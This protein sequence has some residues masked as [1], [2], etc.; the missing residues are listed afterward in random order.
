MGISWDA[1][2]DGQ[3]K[4]VVGLMISPENFTSSVVHRKIHDYLVEELPKHIHLRQATP[5]F[6]HEKTC[7]NKGA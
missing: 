3:L 1:K 6:E 2:A 4:H 5:I 7:G